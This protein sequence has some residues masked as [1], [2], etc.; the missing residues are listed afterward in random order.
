MKPTL[1][2]AFIAMAADVASRGADARPG[3]AVINDLLTLAYAEAD[4]FRE[5]ARR[6]EETRCRA[7]EQAKELAAAI[8]NAVKES[9]LA[10]SFA[11]NSYTYGALVAVI[12]AEAML[13][14]HRNQLDREKETSND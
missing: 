3:V 6:A 12:G 13:A 8:A 10:Y 1:A 14:Q 4:E 11:A 9:R 5:A 7:E 2:E